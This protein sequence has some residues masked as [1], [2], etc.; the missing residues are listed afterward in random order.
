MLPVTIES[1]VAVLRDTQFPAHIGKTVM[2]ALCW[3][4]L[5]LAVIRA[6][7]VFTPRLGESC[8]RREAPIDPVSPLYRSS[9]SVKKQKAGVRT[10]A[11]QAH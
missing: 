4:K 1:L 8:I 9:R 5:G 11:L 10:P 7:R 6:E 3:T 2:L